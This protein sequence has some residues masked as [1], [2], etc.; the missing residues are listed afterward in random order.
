MTLIYESAMVKENGIR[1]PSCRKIKPEEAFFKSSLKKN[2][3][4]CIECR[5]VQRKENLKNVRYLLNIYY[6]RQVHNKRGEPVHYSFEDFY[7]W[8]LKNES[9]MSSFRYW[10]AS[11]Y[12]DAVKPSIIRVDSKKDFT[13]D[14]I[15]VVEKHL[16]SEFKID[17]RERPVTQLTLEGDYVATFPNAKVASE[18]LGYKHYSG[19]SSS[20]RGER[21]SSHGYLWKYA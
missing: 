2:D 19:I 11:G 15:R 16:I 6:Q 5:K 1:C 7:K 3:Y 12:K 10:S 21:K 20:C 8:A 17:P 14:N 18:I 4:R 13:F 9:F